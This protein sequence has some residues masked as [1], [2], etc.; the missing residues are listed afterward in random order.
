M[1]RVRTVLTCVLTLGISLAVAASSAQALVVD[2][3]ALGRTSVPYSPSDHSA[4]DGVAL[5]PGTC[6]DLWSDGGTCASLSGAGVPRVVSSGPCTDPALTSDLILPNFGICFHGGSVLRANETFALTWDAQRSYW[7]GTRGYV[8]QFLR[9]VADGSGSLGSP[10]AV[11]PQYTDPGG[12]AQSSSKFGGGCI[13]YGATGRSACEFGNPTGPGHDYPANGC[14]VTGDSFV[15]DNLVGANT[16]CLTDAQLRGELSAMIAQTGIV[17]RTQ[18]GYTPVVTLLLPAGV[19]TCLDATEKLCSVNG[20]LTPPPSAITTN[21]AGGGLPPGTYQVKTTY[22]TSSGESL[23]SASQTVTATGTISSLT[24]TSPPP[25]VGVTGWY[26]YLEGPGQNRFFRVQHLAT[27]IGIPITVGSLPS[28]PEPPHPPFFCSYH[29]RVDV[30]GTEVAC[31]SCSH[32]RRSPHAMSP[33]RRRS[34]RPRRR[35]S[36]RSTSACGW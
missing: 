11:T 17:G 32:G 10:Y 31:T 28:G 14:K 16:V 24:I 36:S 25:T 27:P 26:A 2:M 19:E 23:P 12:R 5:V 15:D 6:E 13:D 1:T 21:D 3:N 35:S 30:G 7:A 33:T 29:S 4:Y 18:P 34:S 22:L 20:S 8:E 9:D